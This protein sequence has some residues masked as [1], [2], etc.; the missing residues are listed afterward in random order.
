MS[1]VNHAHLATHLWFATQ[2]DL[3]AHDC[4]GLVAGQLAFVR[5]NI[6]D[7][8]DPDNQDDPYYV[9]LPADN[10]VPSP[11]LLA[12]ANSAGGTLPGR[13]SSLAAGWSPDIAP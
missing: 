2:A 5:A 3:Q 10:N 6:G 8:N 13:W 9:Y 12:T 1:A 7:I 11:T 4:S